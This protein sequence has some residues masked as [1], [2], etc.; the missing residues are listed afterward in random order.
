[1]HVE[2]LRICFVYVVLKIAWYL[3]DTRKTLTV[4]LLVVV[5]AV[6]PVT[7]VA[8]GAVINFPPPNRFE[9]IKSA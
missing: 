4:L 3:A 8:T 7:A 2:V 5:V 1:M 9:V 6:A